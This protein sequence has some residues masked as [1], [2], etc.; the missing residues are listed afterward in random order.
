MGGQEPLSIH[1]G[2]PVSTQWRTCGLWAASQ[3]CQEETGPS[4]T[5]QREGKAIWK[6]QPVQ[7]LATDETL[8][9][10]E[11]RKDGD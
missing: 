9:K 7:A 11:K 3:W 1:P 8:A 2:H 10:G 6:E 5:A 4:A